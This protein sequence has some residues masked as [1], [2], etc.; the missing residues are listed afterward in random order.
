MLS[1]FAETMGKQ[2]FHENRLGAKYLLGTI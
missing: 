1:A 2:V